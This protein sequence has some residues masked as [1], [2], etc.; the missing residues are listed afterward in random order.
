MLP[1][2]KKNVVV[3]KPQRLLVFVSFPHFHPL[4]NKGCV[5]NACKR[6]KREP[7]NEARQSNCKGKAASVAE[8]T[9]VPLFAHY[10]LTSERI[11]GDNLSGLFVGASCPI[12]ADVCDE[13]ST[14][15]TA[16]TIIEDDG[17]ASLQIY[18]TR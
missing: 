17:L 15:N 6:R 18:D 5:K 9:P 4:R 10:A 12:L 16:S 3:T 14:T 1:G 7:R 8:T 11:F 2:T 13:N